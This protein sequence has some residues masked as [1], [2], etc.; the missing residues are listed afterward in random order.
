MTGKDFNVL[1]LLGG[2]T[3]DNFLCEMTA[4]CLNI[5]V[6]AGPVEATALGNIILQFIALGEIESVEQ[7]RKIIAQNEKITN[8]APS[9]NGAWDEAYERYVNVIEN[10][11]EEN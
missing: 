3:K 2:G 4:N 1:H 10:Y 5:P 6:S 11:K 9:G 8:Y 7:G